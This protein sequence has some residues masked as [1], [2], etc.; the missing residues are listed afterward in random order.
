[1]LFENK[2]VKVEFEVEGLQFRVLTSLDEKT[3]KKVEFTKVNSKSELFRKLYD[4]GVE[5]C[6]ISKLCNSHYSFV[7]GVIS[8]SREVREL[9]KVSKSDEFRKLFSEGKTPGEVAK[10]TNSN[11][12]FVFGVYKKY[13][14]SLAKETAK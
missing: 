1:M 4:A 14:D 3:A 2:N 11:Y 13:K 12:S 9:Q 6:E 10:L 5:I 7:Y 8:S